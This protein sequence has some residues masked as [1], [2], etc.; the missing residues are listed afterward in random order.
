MLAPQGVV[1]GAS[2]VVVFNNF[3]LLVDAR[4]GHKGRPRALDLDSQTEAYST[5][6]A[7]VVQ[8]RIFGALGL[9][10][11]DSRVFSTHNRSILELWALW[12]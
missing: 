2:E 3:V 7:G 1:V 9:H 5:S 6:T 12:A 4:D 11:Q 10:R 8:S